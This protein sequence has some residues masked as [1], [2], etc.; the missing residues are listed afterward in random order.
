MSQ[1]KTNKRL[2]VSL[3]GLIAVTA[4]VSFLGR[5]EGNTALDKEHFRLPESEA[6][7]RVL[8]EHNGHRVS[9][10]FD[11]VR[12]MV[13]DSLLADRQLV[14]VLFATVEQVEP[15]R[16][17]SDSL[18]DVLKTTGVHVT[19]FAQQQP[20]SELW[21]GG[22]AGKSMAY[23]L[24]A[25][26]P[27]PF[28]V[29]IPGYRVYASGIFEQN[30]NAWRDK[31]VFNFNWRNFRDLRAEFTREASQNFTITMK[32]KYFGIEG[33]TEVDTTKLNDYLDA[34]SLLEAESFYTPG[35]KLF[36][37]LLLVA[38][39]FV[40]EVSDIASR[41]YRM[42]IYPPVRNVDQV[43]GRVG[44]EVMMFQK[45][46]IVPIAKKRSFFGKSEGRN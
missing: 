28:V 8:M 18:T 43:V 22:N 44:N 2:M 32:E 25:G 34:L 41:V 37:S 3:A 19:F 6:V 10:S 9:L 39:S 33:V 23:F 40:I 30:V 13:N 29:G 4:A 7:D 45:R 27:T 36:D 5:R 20:L 35:Q 26:D 14:T 16:V 24:K 11:G 31:R 1:E 17:V 42:E 46:N 38:P 21:V 15:K 12:W